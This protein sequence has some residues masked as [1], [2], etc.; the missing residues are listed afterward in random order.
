MTGNSA[1]ESHAKQSKANKGKGEDVSDLEAKDSDSKEE[2]VLPPAPEIYARDEQLV[3]RCFFL[4]GAE[5]GGVGRRD[6][7]VE[8]I[9]LHMT[10][11]ALWR[12]ASN[13]DLLTSLLLSRCL[14]F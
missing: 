13:G 10:S 4:Q 6:S 14:F 5:E 1:P 12:P 2:P 3:A 8:R 9:G 11:F 7:G